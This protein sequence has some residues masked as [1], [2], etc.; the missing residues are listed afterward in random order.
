MSFLT[1]ILSSLV[2]LHVFEGSHAVPST[3]FLEIFCTSLLPE[4]Y[5]LR[6]TPGHGHNSDTL[7]TNL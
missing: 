3:P 4:G 6:T 1:T 2:L 5:F 7:V